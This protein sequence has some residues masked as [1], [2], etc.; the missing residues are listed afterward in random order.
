[1]EEFPHLC[2]KEG[3][4]T[5]DQWIYDT[6]VNFPAKERVDTLFS[7]LCPSDTR[8]EGDG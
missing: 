4:G 3:I 7:L 6:S 8:T 1:M 5:C 2:M